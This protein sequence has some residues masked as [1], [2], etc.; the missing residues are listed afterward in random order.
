MP[1]SNASAAN[2]TLSDTAQISKYS[3]T[4]SWYFFTMQCMKRATQNYK[5]PMPFMYDLTPSSH[6][7]SFE[8]KTF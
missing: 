3:K 6:F 1:E 7:G 8:L 4:L 2:F 5:A